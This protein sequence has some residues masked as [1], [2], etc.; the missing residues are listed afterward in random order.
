MTTETT[1]EIAIG[2]ALFVGSL[3]G[4]TAL[5]IAIVGRLPPSYFVRPRTITLWSHKPRAQQIAARIAKNALGVLLIVMGA[6]M[7][8]PGVP[9]QG[10]LTVA[11]GVFLLDFPGKLRFERRLAR[12]PR[13]FS[14]LN[15]L[16]KKLGR[17]PFDPPPPRDA[18]PEGETLR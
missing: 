8:L 10:L 7:T 1:R 15:A 12:S 3:I 17:P 13:V 4:T 18:S 6:A 16:R 2:V 14:G 11:V 9:G 5:A